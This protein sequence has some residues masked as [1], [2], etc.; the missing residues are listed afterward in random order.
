MRSGTRKEGLTQVFVPATPG[1]Q[2]KH[3]YMKEI[4]ETGF[5]G[6]VVEQSGTMLK[7]MLQKSDP[8]KAKHC[9]KVD[10]LVF[11]TDRKGSCSST[12]VTY[13]L[14]CQAC[15]NKY[16]R[17]MS[18]SAYTRGNALEQREESSVMWNRVTSMEGTFQNW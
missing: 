5:K 2:L 4:K 8:F 6:R 18:Q 13:K 3:R 9:A 16:I 12:S 11:R 10:C 1:S 17:E 7:S 15:C 14:V